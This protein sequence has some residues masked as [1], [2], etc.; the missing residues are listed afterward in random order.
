MGL[1]IGG[2]VNVDLDLGLT[3]THQQNSPTLISR[4]S[5]SRCGGMISAPCKG[6]IMI[7]EMFVGLRNPIAYF[8]GCRNLV[9]ISGVMYR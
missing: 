1:A 8:C 3:G 4:S 9:S 5:V 2:P 6:L 7:T